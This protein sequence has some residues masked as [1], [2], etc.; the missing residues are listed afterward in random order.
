M[1]NVYINEY[2]KV[3]ICPV[4]GKHYMFLCM[5]Q[6]EPLEIYQCKCGKKK[7]KSVG[8]YEG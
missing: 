2:G 8:N 6:E 5:D 4:C 1:N 3:E 7:Y